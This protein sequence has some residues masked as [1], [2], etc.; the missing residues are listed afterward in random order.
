M[1]N[2]KTILSILSIC[3]IGSA[4][5]QKPTDAGGNT[6]TKKSTTEQKIN[7]EFFSYEKINPKMAL[8][9]LGGK[10]LGTY[11]N[12][13]SVTI[14]SGA[15]K[16]TFSLSIDTSAVK[17]QEI[18]KLLD[19]EGYSLSVPKVEVLKSIAL[20][21]PTE[22]YDAAIDKFLNIEDTSIFN[23]NFKPYALKDIHPSRQR[24]YFVI[25]QIHNF[26]DNLK[27][28]ENSMSATAINRFMKQNDSS[29]EKAKSFLLDNAKTSL[30]YAQKNLDDLNDYEKELK[31]L[32]V[33]QKQ[34]YI[35]LVDKSNELYAKIKAN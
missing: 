5:A 35:K 22:K 9:Y 18:Q 28:A 7:A 24:Y 2:T 19:Q 15:K 12:D 1:T 21:P 33:S 16:L 8:D 30:E 26:G 25:T 13:T 3:F 27:K 32:S 6:Q 20:L 29:E 11:L 34:Y 10:V 17:L 14:V 4:A 23:S 31:M